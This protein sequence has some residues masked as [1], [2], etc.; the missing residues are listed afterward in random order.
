MLV[1]ATTAAGL[2]IPT[3]ALA[4]PV[5]TNIPLACAVDA[6]SLGG[7]FDYQTT[8]DVSV[9]SR[10][11]V[12]AGEEFNARVALNK[13]VIDNDQISRLGSVTMTSSAVKVA[14]E[15]DVELVDPSAG[16]TLENGVLTFADKLSAAKS[17][18]TINITAPVQRV[19]L[20][21]KSETP[22]AFKTVADTVTGQLRG[23][24]FVLNINIAAA[25]TTTEGVR[26]NQETDPEVDEG[27]VS[28][29][30]AE[31]ITADAATV[32]ATA[33]VGERTGSVQFYVDNRPVGDPVVVAEGKATA[34]LPITA[35]GSH[36]VVARFI[37]DAGKNPLEDASAT[38][39]KALQGIRSNGKA[40]DADSYSGTING[41]T[42]TL[43]APVVVTPGST[44]TV[45]GQMTTSAGR[46]YEYGLNA[47]EGVTYVDGTGTFVGGGSV[48]TTRGDVFTGALGYFD[49]QWGKNG[50][51]QVNAGYVGMHSTN[52]YNVFGRPRNIEAQFV[53]P[54]GLAPGLYQFDFGAYKYTAGLN[55]LTPLPGGVFK[56]ED[57]NPAT[58]PPRDIPVEIDEEPIIDD[59]GDEDKGQGS[60][61]SSTSSGG[62]ILDFF[63]NLGAIFTK[64]WEW[65]LGLFGGNKQG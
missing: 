31:E 16:V 58:I 65:F 40:A 57:A 12:Q 46:N 35:A 3:T 4:T 55:V 52:T 51:P 60:S 17:G 29:A 19:K 39:V 21:A 37:D 32:S 42:G 22:V 28:L 38:V 41:Q 7:K 27:A 23:S 11:N 45:Q 10:A 63:R 14:V 18:N 44:V 50:N 20:R 43:E 30:V 26:L 56:V 24:A 47:P 36:S 1:A 15:G 5:K 25:C 54:E 59:N 8:V 34:D 61:G 13:V 48:V 2:M 64:V 9:D 49:P 53:I 33:T 62:G 6:G